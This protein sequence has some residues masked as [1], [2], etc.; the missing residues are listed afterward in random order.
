MAIDQSRYARERDSSGVQYVFDLQE[1]TVFAV[2]GEFCTGCSATRGR[3][4][5][6]TA[7]LAGT[8]VKNG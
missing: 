2:H 3:C 7:A 8:Q 4:G 1:L 6:L 5:E